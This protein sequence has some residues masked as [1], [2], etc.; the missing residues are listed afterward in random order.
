MGVRDTGD[1][2]MVL[3]QR[4]GL[5]LPFHNLEVTSIGLT[6]PH[7]CHP[8]SSLNSLVP[9]PL[10]E[11]QADWS[12]TAADWQ[13]GC[14]GLRCQ[15]GTQSFGFH[16]INKWLFIEPIPGDYSDRDR[17]RHPSIIYPMPGSGTGGM[18]PPS[19]WQQ[20]CLPC[21]LRKRHC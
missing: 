3:P 19:A 18:C 15:S 12:H 17:S 6:V 11:G 9:Q 20:A 7:G 13:E 5:H 14:L 21:V 2:L 4:A 1:I 8:C 16:F 10:R